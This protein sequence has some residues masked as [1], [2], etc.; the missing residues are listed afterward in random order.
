MRH[1]TT[2]PRARLVRGLTLGAVLTGLFASS[3]SAATTQVAVNDTKT[4]SPSSISQTVGGSVR[5]AAT[6]VDEHSVTQNRG[7]FDSGLVAGVDFTRTFSAGTFGYHCQKHGDQ[8]MRGQVRVAPA[9]LARPRGLPFTVK[10]AAPASDTGNR[11]HVRYRVG[12]GAWKVWKRSTSARS[13]VFGAR[14]K[15]VRVVRGR[16][17]SFRVLSRVSVTAKSGLSPVK[18]FR[19]R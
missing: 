10:W 15:P 6:G 17:Y 9:V 3:V 16:T 7:L 12:R 11:F 13:G 2:S 4:F 5:W 19:V 18:R 8:G 1:H 14:S